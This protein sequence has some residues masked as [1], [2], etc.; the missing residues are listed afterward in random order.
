MGRRILGIAF[1]IFIAAWL[2]GM[3]VSYLE[4]IITP[5]IIIGVIVLAAV[6]AY[7]IFQRRGRW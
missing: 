3:A 4:R 6:I 7:R 2:L 5:L 1:S